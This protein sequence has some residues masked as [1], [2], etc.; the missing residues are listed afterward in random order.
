LTGKIRKE[1]LKRKRNFTALM[2]KENGSENYPSPP[3]ST[4]TA[5]P[6]PQQQL[7]F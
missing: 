1:F 6:P 2:E 3:P 4:H 7:S 5:S